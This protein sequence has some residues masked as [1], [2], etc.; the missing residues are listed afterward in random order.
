MG[1]TDRLDKKI[2][3]LLGRN[4]ELASSIDSLRHIEEKLLIEKANNES[5]LENLL[6]HTDIKR[7]REYCSIKGVL[8]SKLERHTIDPNVYD[9][10]LN[11]LITSC[12]D[13]KNNMVEK[14][15]E[16]TRNLET[17][18]RDIIG[19]GIAIHTMENELDSNTNRLNMLYASIDTYIIDS[20]SDSI[21]NNVILESLATCMD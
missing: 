20:S 1:N 8:D 2:K 18:D 16:L 15:L 14:Y 13:I 21:K 11:S 3:Y 12:G 5:E 10:K 7:Y 6:G 19:I 4:S 17:L 9:D